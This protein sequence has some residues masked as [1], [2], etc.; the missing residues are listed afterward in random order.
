[1][2]TTAE[3][4]TA[5]TAQR[6]KVS[7]T[8]R[9]GLDRY[10]ALYLLGIFMIFFSLT[11]DQFLTWTSIQLVLSEKA[12][13]G[14]LALAFLIPLTTNTFD[15]SIGAMLSLSLVLTSWLGV[16]TDFPAGINALLALAACGAFGFLSGFV[17]V[18]WRVN[19]FIATLGMSQIIAAVVLWTGDNRQITGA[20][21][22][23]YREW[24]IKQVFGLPLYFYYLLI[25][26]L[27]LWYVLEHTPVGR[28]M[29]AT[30]G[31]P[32]AAR[33]SGVRTDRLIWASLVASAL[34]AGFAGIVQ[35][36]KQPIFANQIGPPL[37][38]PAIAA[39]FFGA[40]QIKGRPNVWGTIIA[41]YTLAFGVKG[42]QLRF[43]TNSF[44]IEPLFEGVALILAVAVAS[45]QGIVK[46]RRAATAEASED[47]PDDSDDEGDPA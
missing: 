14:I 5:S 18:K 13:V 22:D 6:Q 41:M 26:G 29:F 21:S 31:N 2:S 28:Y 24:G 35:G 30:G 37:L 43:P 8:H 39:V 7:W 17:V 11:Q 1:M 33:L 32:E 23:T 3:E 38:F 15:L 44:W 34:V 10:S 36:W 16:N 47:D 9:I 4:P 40:S 25:V 20:F 42:L 45:R 19:S 12:V 27:I 46:I